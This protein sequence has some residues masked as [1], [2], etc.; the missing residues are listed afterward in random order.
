MSPPS[1]GKSKTVAPD[2]RRGRAFRPGFAASQ[3]EVDWLR[4]LD[5]S[6]QFG[7][8]LLDEQKLVV[9]QF[10]FYEQQTGDARLRFAD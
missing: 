9:A 1:R 7:V 8:E 5:V 6:L 3:V 10:V 4:I 2:V